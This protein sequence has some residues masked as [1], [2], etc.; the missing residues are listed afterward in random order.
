ML[1]QSDR[2]GCAVGAAFALVLDWISIRLILDAAALRL[3]LSPRLCTLPNRH[4]T[5]DVAMAICGD[6][7]VERAI[8]FG[9]RQLLNQH[10]GLWN[11][12]SARA[13][14]RQPPERS[15]EHTYDLQSLM[16][17]SYAV[18]CLRKTT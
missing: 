17:N 2:T 16:R 15:E 9:A 18:S 8:H 5:L 12:L 11:L 14:A 7:A 4:E 13:A 1:A 10:R 6:T 3:G